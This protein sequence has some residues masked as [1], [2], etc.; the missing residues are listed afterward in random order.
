MIYAVETRLLPWIDS[1]YNMVDV[2]VAMVIFT[3]HKNHA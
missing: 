2:A 1:N 3:M